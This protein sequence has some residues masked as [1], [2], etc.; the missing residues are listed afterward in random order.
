[1]KVGEANGLGMELV[2]S[3]SLENVISMTSYVTIP[4]V[5]GENQNNIRS[6]GNQQGGKAEVS[7]QGG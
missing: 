6:T 1:M 7:N 3:W 5:I 2:E 4:L